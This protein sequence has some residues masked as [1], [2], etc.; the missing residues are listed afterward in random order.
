M[1]KYN[2]KESSNLSDSDELVSPEE[3]RANVLGALNGILQN[4][5]YD[6][7]PSQLQEI[8]AILIAHERPNTDP[9]KRKNSMNLGF[10]KLR[11]KLK[12]EPKDLH[13]SHVNL[14]DIKICQ[15]IGRGG[16]SAGVY[17]CLVDGWGC[18]MKQLKREYV[19]KM[20]IQCFER[21]MDILYQL[22]PHPNIVRYLFH[23]AIGKDL[24]LFMQLYSGTLREY[25]DKRREQNQL[26]SVEM[27]CAMALE[28]SD[29][30]AF[31]HEHNVIHRDIKVSQNL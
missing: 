26:L 23:T 27:I 24:C 13:F 19:S 8:E 15:Q 29:G 12:E 3:K 6:A 9:P 2:S 31:L 1:R 5:G 21:E 4:Y 16:S 17:F 14:A 7:S 20:D 18:A 30:L 25:L 28:I 22:P 11:R 10:P